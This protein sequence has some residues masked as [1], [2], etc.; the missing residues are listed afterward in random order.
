MIMSHVDNDNG[1]PGIQKISSLEAQIY[2]ECSNY[3]R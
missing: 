1:Q 3:I 2:I